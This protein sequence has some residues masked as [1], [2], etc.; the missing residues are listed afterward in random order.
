MESSSPRPEVPD[1]AAARAALDDVADA[2]AQVADRIA[3]PWWY[4]VVLAAALTFAFVSMSL[5][6]ASFGVPLLT[7]VVFGL[8]WAV[9]RSTGMSFDPYSATPGARRFSG[10]W[11]LTS[12]VVAGIGMYLE[13]GAE[14]DLAI[15]ASG[16]VIGALTIILGYRI[17]EAVQRDL[18]ADHERAGL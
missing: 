6:F 14:V 8:G 4:H 9:K 1:P 11:A 7:L 12:L 13:W 18:R 2:R 3:I 15:A 10:I 17:N 16:L 5:R